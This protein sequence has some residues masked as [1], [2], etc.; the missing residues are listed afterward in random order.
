MKVVEWPS[1]IIRLTADLHTHPPLPTVF[2]EHDCGPH[3]LHCVLALLA[4]G[5]DS[6]F[7][8]QREQEYHRE[9]RRQL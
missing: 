3:H 5:R 9:A 7:A 6:R 1:D 8:N 4:S 2:Q